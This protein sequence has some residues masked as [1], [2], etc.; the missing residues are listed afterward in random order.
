MN[1]IFP[2]RKYCISKISIDTIHFKPSQPKNHQLINHRFHQHT[3]TTKRKAHATITSH[4]HP[5]AIPTNHHK[6]VNTN[7]NP[8]TTTHHRR[9]PPHN[10]LIGNHTKTTPTSPTR[11][12]ESGSRHNWISRRPFVS[13][14]GTRHYS[15]GTSPP[16]LP[17]IIFSL[18]FASRTSKFINLCARGVVCAP[19]VLYPRALRRRPRSGQISRRYYIILK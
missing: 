10:T 5:K 18:I 8:R 16:S 14:A 1:I 17:R 6:D 15:F 7:V 19:F 12:R 13:V 2:L 11:I 9:Q 3:T 4:V